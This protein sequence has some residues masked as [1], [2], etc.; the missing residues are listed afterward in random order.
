MSGMDNIDTTIGTEIPREPD[1][2]EL[3]RP[4]AARWFPGDD[5]SRE[6]CVNAIRDFVLR[7][8]APTSEQQPT[9]DSF[10]TIGYAASLSGF[11]LRADGLPG[12]DPAAEYR[13]HLYRLR[14]GWWRRIDPPEATR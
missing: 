8:E 1:L 2:G 12:N 7:G 6:L 11:R 5:V 10:M 4:F 9:A 14:N 3:A 13:G